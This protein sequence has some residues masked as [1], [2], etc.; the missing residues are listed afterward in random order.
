MM[1]LLAVAGEAAVGDEA[2]DVVA[3]TVDQRG[4]LLV[5]ARHKHLAAS[6]HT[7]H[8]LVLVQRL[9]RE[10]HRLL[11]QELE[12]IG[13]DRAVEADR[14]LDEEDGLH[15]DLV[16]VVVGVHAVFYQL[17]DGHDQV[18][19][20]EPGE[21][22]VDAA[23]VFVGDAPA[24]LVAERR[25][26]HERYVGIHPVD[27]DGLAEGL[28]DVDA[29]HGYHQVVALRCELCVGLLV[30]GDLGEPRRRREVERYVFVVHLLLDAPVLLE[31]ERVVGRGHEQDVEDAFLHQLLE[32]RVLE[33]QPAQHG[34]VDILHRRQGA[35]GRVIARRLLPRSLPSASSPPGSRRGR[36]S[37]TCGASWAPLCQHAGRRPRWP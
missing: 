1:V 36:R 34:V 16:E 21:H 20:A 30:I 27:L 28:A 11:E 4:G 26:H 8:R 6:A 25:Q 12:Q 9:G 2:H 17:D 32:G 29:G 18:D 14:V 31:D 3:V 15:S 22:V 24:H 35:F 7:E 33:I 37:S 5:V 10:H 19:V 13:H 23:Q